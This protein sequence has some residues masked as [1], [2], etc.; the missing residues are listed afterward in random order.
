MIVSLISV[1]LDILSLLLPH[2][3][4]PRPLKQHRAEYHKKADC[5]AEIEGVEPEHGN[6][7]NL[8]QGLI[9]FGRILFL[10]VYD[11]LDHVLAY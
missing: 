9:S 11:S 5:I 1:L 6:S 3:L 10:K 8:Q 2:Q 4:I 7:V